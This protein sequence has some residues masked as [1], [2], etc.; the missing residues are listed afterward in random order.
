MT[1]E[2][3]EQVGPWLDQGMSLRDIT[4]RLAAPYETVR[5]W[6]YRI[7]PE[8]RKKG[9]AWTDD[10][11]ETLA[12]GVES[13]DSW[14]AI[15]GRLGRSISSVQVHQTELRRKAGKIQRTMH[16]DRLD[17][18]GDVYGCVTV[19]GPDP[20]NPM[21]WSVRWECCGKVRAVAS[22]RCAHMKRKPTSECQEC[23]RDP[24]NRIPVPQ[25]QMEPPI[26]PGDI[27]GLWLRA[28]DA[29]RRRSA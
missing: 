1:T 14:A 10:D 28:M 22:D 17:R 27:Y 7:R 3:R 19:L 12:S 26:D 4:R 18:T 6:A 16:G 21:L 11:N 29:V 15:A 2:E 8:L 9:R 23:K 25:A 5:R 24:N 13:G 20:D